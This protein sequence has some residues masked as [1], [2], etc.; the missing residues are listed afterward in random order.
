MKKNLKKD[1]KLYSCFPMKFTPKQLKELDKLVDD[2]VTVVYLPK[3]SK[4][5]KTTY[6]AIRTN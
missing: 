5:K 1:Y 6:N 4:I 2:S 3:N